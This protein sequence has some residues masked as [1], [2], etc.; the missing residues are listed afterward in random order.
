MPELKYY[1]ET[2]FPPIASL[3]C[4]YLCFLYT[5]VSLFTVSPIIF[6]VINVHVHD[7]SSSSDDDLKIFAQHVCY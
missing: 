1:L 5:T 7:H 3:L 6:R 2:F 4:I